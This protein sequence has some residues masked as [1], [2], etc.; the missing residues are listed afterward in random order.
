MLQ[1]ALLSVKVYTRVCANLVKI[2]H[3]DHISTQ[4]E[5]K[6]K[7]NGLLCMVLAI[8]ASRGAAAKKNTAC[9]SVT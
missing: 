7:N 3:N 9:R 8:L 2:L 1:K 5:T 6:T 4:D